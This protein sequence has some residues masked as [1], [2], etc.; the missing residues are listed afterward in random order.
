MRLFQI[1]KVKNLFFKRL[2]N[3]IL[4]YKFITPKNRNKNKKTF[5]AMTFKHK[6]RTTLR[7]A[8]LRDLQNILISL[9]IF[10]K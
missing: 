2:Y 8:C 7:D 3:K 4:I 1:Y 5:K 9:F 10:I 6:K